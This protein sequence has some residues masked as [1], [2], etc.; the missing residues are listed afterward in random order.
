MIAP[1]PCTHPAAALDPD[2]LR[3]ADLDERVRTIEEF[4]VRELSRLLDLPPGRRVDLH[5]PLH[6]Q[7]VG[8]ILGLHLGRLLETTLGVGPD[9]VRLLRDGSVARLAAD[10]ALRLDDRPRL[11]APGEE[12]TGEEDALVAPGGA[13]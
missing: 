7:G 3:A 11:T 4:I 6:A 12:P 1:K 5:S 10:L 9:V 8:S 13:R 2:A